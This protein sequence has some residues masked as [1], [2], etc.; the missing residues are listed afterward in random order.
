MP[1]SPHSDHTFR[2]KLKSFLLGRTEAGG[3]FL[4]IFVSCIAAWV[5]YH[6][7][8]VPVLRSTRISTVA[9][10]AGILAAAL[11]KAPPRY[12]GWCAAAAVLTL[13]LP[14]YEDLITGWPWETDHWKAFVG[15]KF[16]VDIT[17]FCAVLGWWGKFALNPSKPMHLAW[18]GCAVVAGIA[19]S[20][21]AYVA[22]TNGILPQLASFSS[23]A[24]FWSVAHLQVLGFILGII[25]PV[26][27]LL[28][29]RASDLR[30]AS[31]A[32]FRT[33]IVV[34]GVF[35][36]VSLV[37]FSQPNPAWMFLS[38]AAVTVITFHYELTGAALAIL[39]T[40]GIVTAYDIAK[41]GTHVPEEDRPHIL[42]LQLFLAVLSVTSLMMGLVL[43]QRRELQ[44]ELA[45][46][47]RLA[48]DAAAKKA[49]F[50]ANM[51]HE[52]RSPLASLT[53][54][55]GLLKRAK[56]ERER[57]DIIEN[58]QEGGQAVLDLLNRLLD[59]SKLEA[60]QLTLNPVP[61]DLSGLID[62]VIG[63]QLPQARAKGLMLQL[64]VDPEVPARV[65]ADVRQLMHRL[66]RATGHMADFLQCRLVD[67]IGPHAVERDRCTHAALVE[68][69]GFRHPDQE[70]ADHFQGEEARFLLGIDRRCEE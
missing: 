47:K 68:R 52:I 36:A 55:S 65:L 11:L 23:A 7:L 44:A 12:R 53:L 42:I 48:E 59:F 29:L 27:A 35:V 21:Y 2:H 41:L 34:A 26:P 31:S 66:F 5:G 63:L 64:L 25:I 30:P 70:P 6:Y 4:L 3:T 33:A 38:M 32:T 37:I 16:A 15:L 62:R 50:L 13:A 39:A 10:P 54:F 69:R 43:R 46:A 22:A 45:T 18:A 8:N 20:G 56:T 17:I 14:C 9:L 19:A 24:H 1:N 28:A 61:V 58:L 51:S 49:A 67:Q 40:V 60:G 57:H